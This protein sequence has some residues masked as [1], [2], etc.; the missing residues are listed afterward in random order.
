MARTKKYL[1]AASAVVALAG[2]TTAA[3]ALSPAGSST[4]AAGA[5]A[6]AAG[7]V[8]TAAHAAASRPARVV[9]S[10]ERVRVAPQVELWLT[11][12]GKYWSSPV[13]GTEFRSVTDGNIDRSRLSVTA[14]VE[15]TGGSSYLSGVYTGTDRAAGVVITTD[16]GTIQGTVVRLAGRPGWG[17]WYATSTKSLTTLSHGGRR[18]NHVRSVTVHDA[19][20]RTLATLDPDPNA[21]G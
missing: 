21:S 15:Q 20:G 6:S 13:A 9:A 11:K 7:H 8:T 5:H 1:V 18:T 16:S 17:A 4:V 14:Q 2:M 12:E 10:G 19:S 3:H